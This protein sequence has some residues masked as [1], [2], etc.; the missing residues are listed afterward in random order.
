MTTAGAPDNLVSGENVDRINDEKK[1]TASSEAAM[2][3]E[4]F[5]VGVLWRSRTR[6]RNQ[7]PRL[8]CSLSRKSTSSLLN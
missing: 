1:S 2:S 5:N 6:C 8:N 3:S 7:M 4:A